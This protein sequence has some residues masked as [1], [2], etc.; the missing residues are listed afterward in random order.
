MKAP[1]YQPD[2]DPTRPG[3]I[4]SPVIKFGERDRYMVYAVNTR[5]DAVEWI[6]SD[7]ENLEPVFGLPIIIRQGD[8]QEEVM[9]GLL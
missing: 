1:V 7:L 3:H 5:F 4:A 9:E 2:N 8:T 6:V